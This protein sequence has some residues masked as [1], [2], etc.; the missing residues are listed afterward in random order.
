MENALR[1]VNTGGIGIA[2]YD[3]VSLTSEG[4]V[5]KALYRNKQGITSTWQHEYDSENRLWI[6]YETLPSETKSKVDSYYKNQYGTDIY[7][8]FRKESL[9]SAA[10]SCEQLE[11]DSLFFQKEQTYSPRQLGDL[12]KAAGWLRYLA[13]VDF[14]KLYDL[15][16]KTNGYIYVAQLIRKL[17]LYGLKIKNGRSL[18]R[19]VSEWKRIGLG[20][21]VS[22]KFGTK[23][24]LLAFEKEDGK[25]VREKGGLTKADV[26]EMAKDRI[27]YLYGDSKNANV[28]MVT[29]IYNAEAKEKGFPTYSAQRVWQILQENTMEWKVSREG[30]NVV[31]A[32]REVIIKRKRPDRPNE[33]W[34]LD[35]T[36][37]QLFGTDENGKIAKV[38]Y[39]W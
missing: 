26:F 25:I 1:L 34:S 35:G 38:G 37:I 19:K 21:L 9:V 22:E 39:W 4:N 32:Q 16:G 36:T 10:K 6:L 31:R 29:E 11:V 14:W 30:V 8:A 15:G 7:T 5:K 24:A 12:V 28:G 13:G 23:N 20:C 3:M 18:E 27:I 2:F 33:M 17:D